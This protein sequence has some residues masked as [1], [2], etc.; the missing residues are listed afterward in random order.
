[1]S[2]AAV[3]PL[4]EIEKVE[5]LDV[6]P[7]EV[8]LVTV[9]DHTTASAAERVKVRLEEHLP[10]VKVIIKTANVGVE[11]VAEAAS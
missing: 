2:E 1:M 11:V 10:G 4:L 8:L 5:R 9:P 6:K 3:E 7:G